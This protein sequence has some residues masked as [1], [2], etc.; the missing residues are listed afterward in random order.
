MRIGAAT[1]HI[2][3]MEMVIAAG[4]LLLAGISLRALDYRAVRRANKTSRAVYRLPD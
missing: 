1:R 3:G 4:V 2:T